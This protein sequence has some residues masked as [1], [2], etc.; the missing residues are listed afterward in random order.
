MGHR[1]GL[2]GAVPGSIIG[3]PT[4]DGDK[5]ERHQVNNSCYLVCYGQTSAQNKPVQKETIVSSRPGLCGA[6][7]LTQPRGEGSVGSSAKLSTTMCLGWV[8]ACE[9]IF[10]FEEI[11]EPIV[12][13]I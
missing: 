11:N 5:E 13:N 9:T 8:W 1:V 12:S 3:F 7:H 10:L 2:Q 4:G 6:L